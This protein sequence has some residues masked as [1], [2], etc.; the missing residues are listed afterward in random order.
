MLAS[1]NAYV[2]AGSWRNMQRLFL[3]FQLPAPALYSC[4]AAAS[5]T[6][7]RSVLGFADE[8][9]DLSF[10]FVQQLSSNRREDVCLFRVLSLPGL[11]ASCRLQQAGAQYLETLGYIWIFL[12]YFLLLT[13]YV[14]E[15]ILL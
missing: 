11:Q 8:S 15:A 3:V 12:A 10:A 4:V 5:V 13:F 9:G 1:M 14:I 7:Q 6:V 2:T